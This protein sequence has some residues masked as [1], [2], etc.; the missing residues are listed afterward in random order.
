ML[1]KLPGIKQ[2]LFNTAIKIALD[3]DGKI[4]PFWV[5]EKR[6][7]FLFNLKN[8]RGQQLINENKTAEARAFWLEKA[9]STKKKI[10]SRAEYNLALASELEGNIDQAIEWGLKSFHTL[11]DY[12]TEVYLKKLRAAKEDQLTK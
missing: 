4:S 12:R 7:Y 8:D 9:K 5:S 10:K 6:G 2:A 3:V 11:Y 1:S